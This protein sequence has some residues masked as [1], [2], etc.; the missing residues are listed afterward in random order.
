MLPVLFQKDKAAARQQGD[1]SGPGQKVPLKATLVPIY[2]ASYE[3]R[4][5]LIRL[6]KLNAILNPLKEVFL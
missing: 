4:A 3:Q 6:C 2:H 1:A 5:N